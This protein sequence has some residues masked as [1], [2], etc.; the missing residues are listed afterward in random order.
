M[1]RSADRALYLR[2]G[3]WRVLKRVRWRGTGEIKVALSQVDAVREGQGHAGST[4]ATSTILTR[5][6]TVFCR[7]KHNLSR[8]YVLCFQIVATTHATLPA[9]ETVS[10]S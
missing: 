6:I 9:F 1:E 3:D 10:H 5:F 8:M 2:S 4:P 7:G